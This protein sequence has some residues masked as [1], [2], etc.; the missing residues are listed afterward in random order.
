MLQPAIKCKLT[1]GWDQSGPREP[2][3]SNGTYISLSKL[4]SSE[5]YINHALSEKTVGLYRS[6]YITLIPT[7]MIFEETGLSSV[8]TAMG[9]YLQPDTFLSDV[10]QRRQVSLRN[11]RS[12]SATKD[13]L[14]DVAYD[15]E[16]ADKTHRRAILTEAKEVLAGS[17]EAIRGPWRR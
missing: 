11:G 17:G 3:R 1:G 5:R 15:R 7:W 14:S 10:R 16:A 6:I 2:S 13:S 12:A 8:E 9:E 4:G